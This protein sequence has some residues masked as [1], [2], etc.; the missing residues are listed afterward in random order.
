MKLQDLY[1][2]GIFFF[3]DIIMIMILIPIILKLKNRNK[4]RHLTKLTL[5]AIN[6]LMEIGGSMMLKF[7]QVA[8]RY[9]KSNT[10]LRNM[11]LQER[12]QNGFTQTIINEMHNESLNWLIQYSGVYEKEINSFR[13]TIELFS[14]HFENA[15]ILILISKLNQNSRYAIGS[16][17][18]IILSLKLGGKIPDDMFGSI[19]EAYKKM[20]DDVINAKNKK[21]FKDLLK[22]K[23]IDEIYK[24]L[25]D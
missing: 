4:I 3:L 5:T 12:E 9:Y 8:F 25:K 22:P 23:T 16:M 24:S 15:D 21:Q 6:E 18:A 10:D 20:Y 13:S 11:T 17:E 19:N 2:N 1:A 7:N 14:P